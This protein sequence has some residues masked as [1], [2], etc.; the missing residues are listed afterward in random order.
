MVLCCVSGQYFSDN[1]KLM[2]EKTHFSYSFSGFTYTTT[3]THAQVNKIH[4]LSLT[5]QQ[6][7]LSQEQ[8][9][10]IKQNLH[11]MNMF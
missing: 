4:S 7:T 8:M 1:F 2:K 10:F 9:K 6:V 3:L 5:H 11:F